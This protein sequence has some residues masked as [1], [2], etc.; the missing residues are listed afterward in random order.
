MRELIAGRPR[1]D[2]HLVYVNDNHGDFGARARTSSSARCAAAGPTWSSRSLRRTG[3]TSSP[4]CA[5]RAFYSTTLDYLL[6]SRGVE[7]VVLAGQV[8]EQCILYTALDAYVRHYDVRLPRDAIAGHRRRAGRRR[9][10]DDGAQ[11]ARGARAGGR[12][13]AAGGLSAAPC[14]APVAGG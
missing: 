5:T 11:H 4:R 14:P 10:E 12:L 3:S 9:D 1:R 6:H 13:A 7:T 8:T 2:A